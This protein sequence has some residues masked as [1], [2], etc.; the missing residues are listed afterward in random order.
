MTT[1]RQRPI[2][3]PIHTFWKMSNGHNSAT[4]HPIPFIFGSSGVFGDGGSKGTIC[5]W[6]KSKMAASS[7]FEKKSNGISES[8]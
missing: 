3:G 5:G 4:R 7:H 2:L 6:I 8:H 1:D